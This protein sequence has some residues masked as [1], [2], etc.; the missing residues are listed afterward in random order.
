MTA[1]QS[2]LNDLQGYTETL[3]AQQNIP[4][5]SI[6]I[7]KDGQLHQGA[8]GILN[9]DTGVTATTD[10]IFQIGS[11][12]KVMTTCLVMQLV[13]EGKV[14]LDAPVKQYV[15]D[16]QIADA[17]ASACITVRQLLNHTSGIAGDFF[18]DDRGHQGNLIARFVDR[19]NLLP[20][21]HPVGQQ[22][23]YSN[24]AFAIAGR[25]VEV[26]RGISW[27]QAM[28]DYLFKPLGMHH[29]IA[30]PVDIIR[31]RAAIGHVREG[32]DSTPWQL[33]E[34]AYL[35]LGQAPVGSTP[36]MSAAN[37]ITFAR[38]HLDSGVSQSGARW[39]SEASVKAMQTAQ[40]TLPNVSQIG[41]KQAGLGW[42]KMYYTSAGTETIAHSGATL[43]FL[44]MLQII[45]EQ[46]AAFAVLTNGFKP[47]ASNAITRDLLQVVAGIDNRE[48]EPPSDISRTPED[49]QTF[50]GRYDSLDTSVTI[51]QQNEGL[52]AHVV[53]HIDP[54]PPVDLTL[55]PVDN[56]GC[57]AVYTPEGVRGSNVTFVWEQGERPAYLF[58]AGR[59]NQ[60]K[61]GD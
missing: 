24:S 23:S 19:C 36:T 31:Y 54:L 29:A 44:S 43:G 47:A 55:V 27:Y 38:A 52:V 13:D 25:L 45:P 7:W 21:V 35:T 53:Y 48:P 30:D 8:A 6:A 56:E 16:F 4:A 32:D 33:P 59:L 39:L 34:H 42:G 57:F 58:F 28:Q 3:V 20:L 12:T 50:V 18:P 40:I 11:I 1:T 60:R 46:N 15:Q 41:D 10:S 37:L 14:D 5:A 51:T 9:I 2:I 49:L 61:G 17:E 22:Y 26:V